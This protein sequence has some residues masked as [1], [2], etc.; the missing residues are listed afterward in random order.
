MVPKPGPGHPGPAPGAA[1]LARV[2]PAEF[3][4]SGRRLAHIERRATRRTGTAG[5]APG[6]WRARGRVG[7]RCRLSAQCRVNTRL[8]LR[9][10]ASCTNL[11]AGG[12]SQQD[13]GRCQAR[14]TRSSSACATISKW[15]AAPSAS[16]CVQ[17]RCSADCAGRPSPQR[18][19][20][21]PVSLTARRRLRV[22]RRWA[23]S[24]RRSRA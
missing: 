20:S 12:F 19:G 16:A 7:Y 15:P 5:V 18:V 6:C 22:R 1:S 14:A 4:R 24:A 2:A 3:S 11:I 10:P 8:P 17:R 13:R 21:P 23:L 9:Q